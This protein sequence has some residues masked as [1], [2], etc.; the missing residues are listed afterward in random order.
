VLPSREAAKRLSRSSSEI[1][2]FFF[3]LLIR[4]RASFVAIVYSHVNIEL[5]FLKSPMLF[6]AL[7]NVF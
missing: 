2:L 4:E 5:S 7:I 3:L 6:H 1:A